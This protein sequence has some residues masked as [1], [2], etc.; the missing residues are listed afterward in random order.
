MSPE[1]CIYFQEWSVE[2][3]A[4]QQRRRRTKSAGGPPAKKAKEETI[5]T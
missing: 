5:D 1:D 4:K 3:V 2:K